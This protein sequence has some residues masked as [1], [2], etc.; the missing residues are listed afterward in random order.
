MYHYYL[1]ITCPFSQG[2]AYMTFQMTSSVVIR[3]PPNGQQTKCVLNASNLYPHSHVKRLNVKAW[4]KFRWKRNAEMKIECAM[5]NERI[6][7]LAS[8]H[9]LEPLP[10]QEQMWVLDVKEMESSSK[11]DVLWW[12]SIKYAYRP[13]LLV[14]ARLLKKRCISLAAKGRPFQ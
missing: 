12:M 8:Y 3:W 5:W 10:K 6:D 7:G 14:I 9:S 13:K 2:K 4:I 11:I 1:H